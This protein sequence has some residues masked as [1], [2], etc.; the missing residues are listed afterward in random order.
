MV[1]MSQAEFLRRLARIVVAT[2]ALLAGMALA[3][4]TLA[5]C[6]GPYPSFRDLTKT[7]TTIV[8]GDVV[9]V[10][11]GGAWDPI[12]NGVASRFTL[13]IGYVLRGEAE[14]LVEIKDLPTQPCAAVVGARLGDRI[15]L[16][17]GG[18][19]F[20]PPQ[21]VNMVAWIDAVPP[22][23]FGPDGMSQAE[24]YSLDGL[25]ALVGVAPL[26][27]SE[28]SVPAPAAE[29]PASGSESTGLFVALIAAVLVA[30]VAVVGVSRS[31]REHRN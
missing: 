9:A 7:A 18:T 13:R 26:Q 30:A 16:A 19:D 27:T 24:T 3:D 15:A 4:P 29:S 20:E 14:P 28:P 5:E 23:G 1:A 11:P 8:V 22:P 25:F 21:K 12:D 2:L 6:D 31:R 17:I 10:Q